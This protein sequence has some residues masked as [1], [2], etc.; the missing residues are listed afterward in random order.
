VE[1]TGRLP[2]ESP[3]FEE[4]GLRLFA[5]P[6]NAAVLQRGVSG[7]PS[8]AAFLKAHLDRIVRGDYFGLLAFIEMN[9]L[10]ENLLQTIRLAVRDRKRVATCLGFGPRFLHSTGQ[11]YKG[12]PNTGVFFQ[13]TCDH[14]HDLPVPGRGYTFGTVEEAQA[15]GDFRVLADRGR[16]LLRLHL[17]SDVPAGLT[18]IQAA[19]REALG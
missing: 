7:S 6:E 2:A 15:R 12:G 16:R 11:A 9:L 3:F 14:T 1:A 18:A 8:L 5:D 10:H 4:G 19:L 17:G 13:V